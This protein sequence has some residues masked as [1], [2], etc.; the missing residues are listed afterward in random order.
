MVN[1]HKKEPNLIKQ[2]HPLKPPFRNMEVIVDIKF[3]LLDFILLRI[4]LPPLGSN[5]F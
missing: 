2:I 1:G 5:K 3:Y 4:K